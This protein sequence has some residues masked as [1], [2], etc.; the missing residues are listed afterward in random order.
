MR[1][2]GGRWR[3]RRIEPPPDARARP[4]TDRVREAWM[5]ILADRLPGAR[6]VDLFAGSGA[7]GLEALSRGAAECDFVELSPAS[8]AALQRN[9][10][11]LGVEAGGARVHRADALRYAAKLE[12]LAFDVAFADPPY[13]TNHASRIAALFRE[14]PFARI[15]GVEHDRHEDVGPGDHR[16]YGRTVLTFLEAP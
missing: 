10:A 12:P 8:L 3:S 1:I 13:T 7:M 16:R 11:A 14:R 6:V 9:L 2:V 5:S 15:L 4:T